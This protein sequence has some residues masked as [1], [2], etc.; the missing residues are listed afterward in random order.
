MPHYINCVVMTICANI[1]LG[2]V[3]SNSH[4]SPI[5]VLNHY[6]LYAVHT[7]LWPLGVP[8]HDSWSCSKVAIEL[9]PQKVSLKC[10]VYYYE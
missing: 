3:A 1:M 6:D 2:M 4:I 7:F 8:L 9:Q 5:Q 10:Y